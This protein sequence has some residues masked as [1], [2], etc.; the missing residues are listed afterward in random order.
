MLGMVATGRMPFYLGYSAEVVG[1]EDA[2]EAM[3]LAAERG[4][5]GE[6]Y[7]ISDRWLSSREVGDIAADAA[8]VR[9]PRIGLPMPLLMTM[10]RGNDLA[11]RL[12]DRDLQ[13]AAAGMRIV[14]RMPPLDHTKAERE[15]GWTPE[16][17]E[18]SISDA[19][20]FFREQSRSG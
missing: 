16:P 10:A 4:R 5:N 6:R 2:A 3:L 11:A 14:Q 19:A 8:G 17:V 9:R 20:R 7:I 12:L 1:I 15:L 18:R 13:F